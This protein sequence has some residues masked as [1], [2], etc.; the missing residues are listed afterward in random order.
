MI[1]YPVFVHNRKNFDDLI[2]ELYKVNNLNSHW[3]NSEIIQELKYI[4]DY[5]GNLDNQLEL[6]SE[7]LYPE[8]AKIVRDDF[9]ELSTSL[10]EKALK[11][12]REDIYDLNLEP[13]S[14]KKKIEEKAFQNRFKQT[15]LYQRII[16]K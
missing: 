10:E 11:F 12:F 9:F 16:N 14:G 2:N 5:I 3:F 1:T 4:Q 8:I 13:T 6:N 15:N 7:E